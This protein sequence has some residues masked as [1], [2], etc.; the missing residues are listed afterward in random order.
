MELFYLAVEGE[1]FKN[2][3]WVNHFE[4]QSTEISNLSPDLY[5]FKTVA[6][7]DYPS[8]DKP[9]ESA[10]S[11]ITEA[12]P[13]PGVISKFFF[14]FISNIIVLLQYKHQQEVLGSSPYN[15]FHEQDPSC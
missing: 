1:E 4:T 14:L 13:L 10:A 9:E 12:R 15:K 3:S 5:E 6:R 8:I 11:D 7:N 2:T